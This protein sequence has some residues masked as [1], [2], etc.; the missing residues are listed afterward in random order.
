M[1]DDDRTDPSVRADFSKQTITLPLGTVL[2]ILSAFLGAGGT[3]SV[4][5][6]FSVDR[7]VLERIEALEKSQS[8]I[9]DKVALTMA[10]VKETFDIVNAAHPPR[11]R[12]GVP[13]QE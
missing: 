9:A 2:I 10:V 11:G 1:A 8:E 7:E 4:Q 6:M 13:I 5:S 12:F 3:A